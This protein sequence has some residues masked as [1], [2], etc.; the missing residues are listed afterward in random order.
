MDTNSP[1]EPNH[2]QAQEDCVIEIEPIHPAFVA[3]IS[4]IDLVRELCEQSFTQLRRA[5]D[6]FSILVFSGQ[7]MNDEQQLEF[8]NWWGPMTV[9][10][11]V[12]P[13]AGTPFARQSNLDVGT[14]AIIPLDDR[15]MAYQQGNY[16]WHADSTF[17]PVPSLCSILTAREAPPEGGNTEFASTRLAYESLPDADKVRVENLVV[18]HHLS[19]SRGRDGFAF[20]AEEEAQHPPVWHPLVRSNPVTGRKSLL[21]GA[22]AARI[23]GWTQARSRVLLDDLLALA[24]RPETIYSHHWLT[25]DVIIWDNRSALHRA[26]AYDSKRYRRLMQRTTIQD[27]EV[28]Q[29]SPYARVRALREATRTTS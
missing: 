14:G 3:R 24:T 22:H 4:G 12:N 7:T 17:K 13:A 28:L 2:P 6:D 16:Q 20:T 11:G 18:E 29:T 21:I 1:F 25:D 23:V 27:P 10:K 15:R 5:L 8:S 19:F 26:N 9:T